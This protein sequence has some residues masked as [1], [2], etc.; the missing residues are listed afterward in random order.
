[1]VRAEVQNYGLRQGDPPPCELRLIQ[2][3]RN[4][5]AIEKDD[6]RL[7]WTDVDCFEGVKII[8]SNLVDICSIEKSNEPC[9]VVE[10]EKGKKGY[11]VYRDP[12]IYKFDLLTV[13]AGASQ[14]H[15]RVAVSFDGS[16]WENIHILSI[17]T[18]KK[19]RSWFWDGLLGGAVV[20][21]LAMWW[22][23][24]LYKEL[25]YGRPDP[26]K[27]AIAVGSEWREKQQDILF[28]FT[29]VD[30]PESQT[31]YLTA[32]TD[33]GDIV[34]LYQTSGGRRSFIRHRDGSFTSFEFPNSSDSTNATGINGDGEVVGFYYDN[35]K[36]CNGSPAHGFL[37]NKDGTFLS[38]SYPGANHTFAH[39]INDKKEVVGAYE[40]C[41]GLARGFFRKSDGSM[42][43]LD[44]PKAISTV[45]TGIN[46]RGEIIGYWR[47][48]K[49]GERGFLRKEDGQFIV[50]HPDPSTSARPR[51][52]N[53]SGDI[54][55][56]TGIGPF[57][58]RED[59]MLIP[60]FHPVC[61]AV[62][63]TPVGIR[64]TLEIVGHYSIPG[65]PHGFI[66]KMK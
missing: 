30:F 12:G 49:F 45:P 4:G 28:D 10:Y 29:R 62:C 36:G 61:G 42:V 11:G 16:N 55:G 2:I 35:T 53:N 7:K 39:A 40:D 14:G 26:S 24:E 52:I 44:F 15:A 57:L 43:P 9:L 20:L 38:F 54:V 25:V 18:S 27:Q 64:S 56:E 23:P 19:W 1:M 33:G 47:D 21:A 41:D 60:I 37:R 58:R 65:G 63:V 6:S 31:T 22:K 50:I 59:G 8:R 51:G 46:N 3:T 48:A 34:G 13:C 17:K 5:M 66:A 32:I